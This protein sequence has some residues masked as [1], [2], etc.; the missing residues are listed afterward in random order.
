M[1]EN[2]QLRDKAYAKLHGNWTEPVLAALIY[3]AVSCV[4]SAGTQVNNKLGIVQFILTIFLINPMDYGYNIA[5]VK[6]CKDEDKNVVNRMFDFFSNYGKILGITFL[7]TIYIF[8]WTLLLIVPGII[9][10]CSYSMSYY[11]LNDNP[12]ISAEEAICESMKMTDGYKMKYFLLCLSFIPWIL[13][14]ILTLGIG[15]LWVRPYMSASRFAFYE[16][17]KEERSNEVQAL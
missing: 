14:G 11:I 3:A 1:L 6:F 12:N 2:Y 8:L 17:L 16:N 5:I 15:L 7:K 9:K 10:A 4:A 13:L